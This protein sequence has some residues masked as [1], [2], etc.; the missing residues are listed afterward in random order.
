[1]LPSGQ[2]FLGK[3]VFFHFQ[4]F[5]WLQIDQEWLEITSNDHKYPPGTITNDAEKIQKKFP[6]KFRILGGVIDFETN[7]F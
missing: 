5:I 6:K 1:M 7:N 4:S 3:I 2:I